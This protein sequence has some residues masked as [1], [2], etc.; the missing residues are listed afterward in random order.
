MA[1]YLC[2][3]YH[4]KLH[5][6][7]VLSS[8][9]ESIQLRVIY[10]L[11]AR[12]EFNNL[13]TL[14]S[15]IH[16]NSTLS[17]PVHQ[18]YSIPADSSL[19]FPFF[20]GGFN[21]IQL[22]SFTDSIVHRWYSVL[23]CKCI[24]MLI[25]SFYISRDFTVW[26]PYSKIHVVWFQVVCHCFV[27]GIIVDSANRWPLMIDPQ[28]QANKWV[29]NM[30]KVNKLAVI[31]LSDSNY[32][33]TLENCL[34]VWNTSRHHNMHSIFLGSWRMCCTQIFMYLSIS[35]SWSLLLA[36]ACIC[37]IACFYE[38]SAPVFW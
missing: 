27:S 11:V 20:I 26:L 38:M 17:I 13:Q 15:I 9:P 31:K 3:E 7:R 24:I 1:K 36:A 30:E 12:S 8:Q 6:H 32:T 22:W 35:D 29:K 14:Q 18:Y 10:V 4:A 34:Q 5:I 33:R 21:H 23:F 37:I 2:V 28:G 16:C 19:T 25:L